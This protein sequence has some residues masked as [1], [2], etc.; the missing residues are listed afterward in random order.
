MRKERTTP[1][2]D[3][4]LRRAISTA[5]SL[6][7]VARAFGLEYSTVQRHAQRLGVRS[8]YTPRAG[9][10]DEATLYGEL[11]WCDSFR[12]VAE[13]YA[14]PEHAVRNEAKRLGITAPSKRGEFGR[15][16]EVMAPFSPG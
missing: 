2:A 16:R 8:L 4:I 3:E 10:P 1:P 12:D 15:T 11:Y 6:D 5:R 14:V 9:L 13:R 7:E